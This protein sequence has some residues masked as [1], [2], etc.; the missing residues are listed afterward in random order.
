MKG[1]CA[2]LENGSVT[3]GVE[4]REDPQAIEVANEGGR[5]DDEGGRVDDQT[6]DITSNTVV[7]K[8]LI[9]IPCH[10]QEAERE[11]LLSCMKDKNF[12]KRSGHFEWDKIEKVFAE[13]A[14]NCRIYKRGRIRLR[15]TIKN[16]V[17]HN[18]VSD[19]SHINLNDQTICNTN[20]SHTEGTL[21]LMD[22]CCDEE[23]IHADYISCDDIAE[24]H[25]IAC[26]EIREIP[27]ASGNETRWE[28]LAVLGPTND[29]IREISSSVNNVAHMVG[30]CIKV[31]IL[32]D[33]EREFV[34]NYGKKRIL[35]GHNIDNVQMLKAY[36]V[37]FPGFK[38]DGDILKKCWN[39]WKDSAAYKEFIRT[40][41][42]NK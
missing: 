14:D 26:D 30:A 11:L 13:N 27:A 10:L 34:R 39:N 32:D 15:S 31:G 18:T 41:R 24:E 28:P 38:R 42:L 1:N 37:A 8:T 21:Y 6:T 9:V 2:D 4:E 17:L 33:N 5:V 29:E 22:I 25:V 36:K 12:R 3:T 16:F 19:D 35:E 40:V 7:E 20:D 23:L